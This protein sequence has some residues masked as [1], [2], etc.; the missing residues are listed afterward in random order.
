LRVEADETNMEGYLFY[1]LA[2]QEGKAL[3]DFE[4][5]DVPPPVELTSVVDGSLDIASGS[6]PWIV[7][8][9]SAGAQIWMP[10]KDLIPGTTFAIIEFGP[11][12][13]N[14]NPELGKRFMVAYLKAV[15]QLAEGKTGRNMELMVKFT[16]LE[17]DLLEEACWAHFAKGA[18]IN[19]DSV[20]AFQEYLFDRGLI[21]AVVPVDVFYDPTYTD[22]AVSVVGTAP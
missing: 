4:L 5:V 8:M 19:T 22:H 1:T 6:E 10:A 2:K 14:D 16:G 3:D 15:N 7:R 11:S 13:V 9:V 17:R 12:I 21:D 20:I 18:R